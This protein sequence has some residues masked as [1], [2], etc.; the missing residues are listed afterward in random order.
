MVG[1]GRRQGSGFGSVASEL[2]PICLENGLDDYL[3]IE[4]GKGE[5]GAK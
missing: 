1:D 3:T 4:R 5:S 2:P